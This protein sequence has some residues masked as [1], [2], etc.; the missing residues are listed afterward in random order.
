MYGRNWLVASSR[1]SRACFRGNTAKSESVVPTWRS[2]HVSRYSCTLYVI[3]STW[4]T[5]DSLIRRWVWSKRHTV[6]VRE[7][8][9]HLHY[10]QQNSMCRICRLMVAGGGEG[11]LTKFA[12]PTLLPSPLPGGAPEYYYLLLSTYSVLTV[13]LIYSGTAVRG[14]ALSESSPLLYSI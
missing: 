13:L 6:Y 12:S 2:S 5:R 9:N 4:F 8:H 1:K 3:R 11:K 10:T 14:S 7:Q